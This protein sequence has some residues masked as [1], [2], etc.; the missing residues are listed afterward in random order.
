MPATPRLYEKEEVVA[1][2]LGHDIRWFRSNVQVLEAQ[3]GFP[4]I[5]PAI[6]LRHREAVELWARRRNTDIKQY[7]EP[8][9]QRSRGKKD[10]F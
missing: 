8:T 7:G 1:R 4:K 6:G 10:A 3:F 9:A 5:D 2:L